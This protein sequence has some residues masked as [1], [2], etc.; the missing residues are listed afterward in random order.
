MSVSIE[1]SYV[2]SVY[3]SI[4][5]WQIPLLIHPTHPSGPEGRICIFLKPF[6]K[7]HLEV[8]GNMKLL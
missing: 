5:P 4:S 2:H 7:K 1:P 3:R 6:E 8:F